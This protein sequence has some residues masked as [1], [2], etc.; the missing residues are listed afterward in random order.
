MAQ[1]G[2]EIRNGKV[3]HAPSGALLLGTR[4]KKN[5]K[6]GD[7]FWAVEPF[8]KNVESLRPLA[9][10]LELWSQAGGNAITPITVVGPMDINWPVALNRKLGDVIGR[11]AR[12]AAAPALD[13]L[14]IENASEAKVL[15]Q[16]S[17]SQSASIASLIDL[18][19]TEGAELIAVKTQSKKGLD[20]LLL[21]SFAEGLIANSSIPV[22]TISKKTKIPKKIK[23]ILV[24]TD[25]SVDSRAVFKKVVDWASRFSARIVLLN[26]FA[27]PGSPFVYSALGGEVDAKLIEQIFRDAEVARKQHGRHWKEMAEKQGVKCEVNFDRSIGD[28][29][30]LVLKKAK[31]KSADLIAMVSYRSS[32]GRALL[33]S[34]ARDVLLGAECPVIVVHA[35]KK[36]KN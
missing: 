4:A 2:K 32:I 13:K 3:T 30:E 6:A 23:T 22:L 24:P 15:I 35:S 28:L 17:N 14:N 21:G 29:E 19:A 25:F 27:P 7:I 34:T 18:A 11:A 10:L 16:P 31:E 26:R 33:G 20:R 12:D 9:Q 1:S 8:E 5:R 36:V